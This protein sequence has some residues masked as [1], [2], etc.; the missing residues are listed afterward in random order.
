MDQQA[1]HSLRR[2]FTEVF[3]VS[4][5][6]E[7]LVSFD[8]TQPARD[9]RDMMVASHFG[10]VG[11]RVAGRVTGYVLREELQDGSCGDYLRHF[12]K[13]EVIASSAPLAELVRRLKESSW[14]FVKVLGAV[15]GIVTKTDLQKP[16]MRMWLFGMVTLIEMRFTKM[17]EQA[18]PMDAWREF[19]SD[20]RIAKAESL[21]AERQRRNQDVRLLDCLQLSDKGQIIAR[22]EEIRSLTLFE[23]RRQIEAAI[24]GVERLRNNLAHSQD[25]IASD[26]DI[27]L[28]LAEN[29]DRV[30]RGPKPLQRGDSDEPQ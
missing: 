5:L 14:L 19:L 17:I 25:I 30:I 8:A 21:F 18:L 24:K 27:I 29:L 2:V 13:E 7:P 10:V 26:W 20:S 15:G 9:V 4:D 23:S 22:N 28:Q 16:A 12:E 1:Q 3:S 11:L 6:A